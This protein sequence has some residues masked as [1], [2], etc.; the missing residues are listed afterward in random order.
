MQQTV[1]VD[2][3]DMITD[4]VITILACGSSCYCSAVVDA[5]ITK[6]LAMTT[7]YGLS[8]YCSAVA[9]AVIWDAD[10]AMKVDT[11]TDAAK[12]NAS[13]KKTFAR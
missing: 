4:Q 7:V 10:V 11:E 8:C 3:K 9:D 2:A 1:D 12:Q 5:D 13:Y 6:D